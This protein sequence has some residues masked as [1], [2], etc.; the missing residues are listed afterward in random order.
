[1]KKIIT[2]IAF[3]SVLFIPKAIKASS[4]I[5]TAPKTGQK[6]IIRIFNAEN[7]RLIR[8]FRVYPKSFKSGINIAVGDVTGNGKDNIIVAPKTGWYPIVKIYTKKGKLLKKFPAYSKKHLGGLDVATGDL[9]NNGQDE[10][11]TGPGAGTPTI[12]KIF[13]KHGGQKFTQGFLAFSRYFVNGVSVASGD[14]DQD[15][16]D[17]IIVGAGPGGS[18]H[19][20]IFE[21]YGQ[22]KPNDFFAFKKTFKGGVNV[23][24]GDM[25]GD[26]QDVIG[27]CQATNGKKCKIYQYGIKSSPVKKIKIRKKS[28]NIIPNFGNLNSNNHQKLLIPSAKKSAI[29]SYSYTNKSTQSLNS[30]KK[31]SEITYITDNEFN[32][33]FYSD[34]QF[35]DEDS[36]WRMVE[37]IDNQKYDFALHGGDVTQNNT[38][39]EWEIFEKVSRKILTKKPKK[40]LTHSL[41]PAVGNHEPTLEYY[42]QIF[43]TPPINQKYYSFD[44]KN[45]HMISI[46]TEI[47]SSPG[48]EQ[49]NW[50]INDLANTNKQWKIVFFHRP[51][52]TS[53]Y[54]YN[55]PHQ[56]DNAEVRKNI[57][58]VLEQF[59][60]ILALNG[61]SHIF[62]RTYPIYQGQVNYEN[63]ITYYISC[64]ADPNPVNPNWWT[65]KAKKKSSFLKIKIK[66]N[67]ARIFAYSEYQKIFDKHKIILP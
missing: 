17:E 33:I 23:A 31:Y 39:N 51:A 5:V 2:L 45:V 56:Q 15:G 7:N 25:N 64:V 62:E 42:F 6:A 3:I 36:H 16:R 48:S 54:K 46:D 57:V 52:Y 13:D 53:N 4:I 18:P 63:G 37:A 40:E 65:A 9:D 66:D 8:K 28:G 47:D 12:I 32:F 41:Y 44:Y 38:A 59:N 34:T 50:L 35:V 58:P 22:P 14:I 20:R 67:I 30:N 24:V 1:M 21:K 60:V 61:H 10:I 49:Y 29:K 11:I 26:G 43:N 55:R 19:V 27:A